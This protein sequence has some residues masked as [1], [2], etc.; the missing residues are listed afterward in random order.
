M[1]WRMAGIWAFFPIIVIPFCTLFT[2]WMFSSALADQ[3]IDIVQTL[4]TLAQDY[5]WSEFYDIGPGGRVGP[6]AA[7][8][9]VLWL[10][11]LAIDLMSVLFHPEVLGQ[12]VRF[13]FVFA[14]AFALG[15]I[16]SAFHR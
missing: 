1:A 7:I 2:I 12:Y 14:F 4:Q 9:I 8:F 10:P 13:I 15:F 16:P 3:A 11:I 6:L 5:D